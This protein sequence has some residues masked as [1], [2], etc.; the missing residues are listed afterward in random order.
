[1]SN[2][3]REFF[4]PSVLDPEPARG[5]AAII[6]FPVARTSLIDSELVSVRSWDDASQARHLSRIVHQHRSRL[7][8]LG[9]A[10]PLIERDAREME[11]AFGL[12]Q[13]PAHERARA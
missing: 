5:P 3:Q 11:I 7:K 13:P 2:T 10:A 4:V 8:R 12:V 9:V 1:M 6:P